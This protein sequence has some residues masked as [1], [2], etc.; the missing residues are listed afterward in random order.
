MASNEA[1]FPFDRQSSDR[2]TFGRVAISSNFGDFK[3]V[4]TMRTK[5]TYFD[6]HKNSEFL[7][8]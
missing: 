7:S 3:K 6:T 1:L 4:Y 5:Y 2:R 8:Q